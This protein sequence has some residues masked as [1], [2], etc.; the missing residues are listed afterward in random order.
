LNTLWPLL[1]S[2][3]LAWIAMIGNWQIW[4]R[5]GGAFVPEM[6]QPIMPKILTVFLAPLFATI[7]L[8][9]YIDDDANTALF[10]WCMTY[11]GVKCLL[12]VGMIGLQLFGLYILNS[13]PTT[14]ELGVSPATP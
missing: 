13:V 7:A 5:R 14:E 4:Q 3:V 9:T 8:F 1:L 10:A 11:L 6:A 2:A 12:E